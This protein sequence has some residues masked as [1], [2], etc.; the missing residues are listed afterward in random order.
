MGCFVHILICSNNALRLRGNKICESQ[1]HVNL[2]SKAGV[3][4]CKLNS[5]KQCIR[6]CIITQLNTHHIISII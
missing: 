3:H 6:L 4:A 5:M 1:Y 2:L